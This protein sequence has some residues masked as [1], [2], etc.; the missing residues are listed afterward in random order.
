LQIQKKF[1][2]HVESGLLDVISPPVE[3]YPDLSKLRLTLQDKLDRVQWRSKQVYNFF[4]S[5]GI[6]FLSRKLK[7]VLN[8]TLANLLVGIS[9]NH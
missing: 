1:G 5:N 3:F 2:E 8:L 4:K 7:K 6:S 9:V